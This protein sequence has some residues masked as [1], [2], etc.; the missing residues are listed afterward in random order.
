[1]ALKPKRVAL[2]LP[3]SLDH[4]LEQLSKLEGVPK[5]KIITDLLLQA[6]PVLNNVLE[7]LLNIQAD[8]ANAAQVVRE[9]AAKTILDG[10]EQLGI[11][12]SESKKL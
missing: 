8:K 7:A 3:H 6:E 4:T 2:T 1:M 9:F 5:T 10:T 11:I 12:A